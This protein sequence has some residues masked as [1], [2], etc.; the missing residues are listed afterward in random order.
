MASLPKT[1]EDTVCYAPSHR[2]LSWQAFFQLNV[3]RPF[4]DIFCKNNAFLFGIRP[5]LL[6]LLRTRVKRHVL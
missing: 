1:L 6:W 5:S 2:P 4:V 3:V